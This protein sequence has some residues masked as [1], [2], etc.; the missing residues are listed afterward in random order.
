MDYKQ[1]NQR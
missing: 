1:E